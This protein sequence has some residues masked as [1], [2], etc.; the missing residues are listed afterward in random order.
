V[1]GNSRIGR[2]ARIG[3]QRG[4]PPRPGLAGPAGPR[5]LRDRGIGTL[6]TDDRRLVALLAT[7]LP[8][9]ELLLLDEPCAGMSRAGIDTVL[10]VFSDQVD[11]DV[12]VL[13]SSNDFDLVERHCDRVGILRNGQMVAV[14][15]LPELTADRPR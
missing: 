2:T 15:A 1:V 3:H 13:F 6:D 5:S 8:E 11:K 14:G 10:D 9:P 4:P 7:L 12:P